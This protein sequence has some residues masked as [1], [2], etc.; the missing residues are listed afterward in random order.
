MVASSPQ[1]AV[2][3]GAGGGGKKN[4]DCGSHLQKRGEAGPVARSLSI[5]S[6][7]RDFKQLGFQPSS[8]IISS[9]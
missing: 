9:I 1:E 7:T 5:L 3:G 2:G 8:M 6:M 4:C